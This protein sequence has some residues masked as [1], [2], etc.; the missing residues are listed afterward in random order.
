M[1]NPRYVIVV[2]VFIVGLS[3]P[4]NIGFSAQTTEAPQKRTEIPY[5]C[6]CT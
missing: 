1:K 5:R 3:G 2:T 6:T 4:F